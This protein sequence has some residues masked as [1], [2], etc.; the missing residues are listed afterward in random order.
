MAI[1]PAN[2]VDD[3]AWRTPQPSKPVAPLP[4]HL[5]GFHVTL[6]GPPDSAKMAINAMNSRLRALPDEPPVVTAL[7]DGSDIVPKWGADDEGEE[8]RIFI[9]FCACGICAI[10][11]VVVVM[12]NATVWR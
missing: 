12:I 8:E 7:V 10:R 3:D 5:Q 6:F 11:A 9:F 4:P 2:G 1:G